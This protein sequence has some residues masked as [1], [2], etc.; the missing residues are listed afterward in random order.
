MQSRLRGKRR[1]VA[2]LLALLLLTLLGILTAGAVSATA[3]RFRTARGSLLDGALDAA[4]MNAIGTVVGSA[5]LYGLADLTFAQPTTISIPVPPGAGIEPIVASVVATRFAHGVVWLVAYARLA[6]DSAAGERRLNAVL[7]YPWIGELPPA[8]VVSR[9]A[10]HLDPDVL[11]SADTA[12]DLDC[13]RLAPEE[14]SVQRSDSAAFYL[15]AFQRALLDSAAG[16]VHVHG[17]TTVSGGSFDGI[18]IVDGTLTVAGPW[19]AAGLVI[20]GG[21]VESPSGL[22]LTGALL[23]FADGESPAVALAGA[24]LRYSPCTVARAFRRALPLRL[25]RPRAWAEVF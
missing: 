18:L 22:T 13:P 4:A 16:V 10:V 3:I 9:G 19:S 11:V 2:L 6:A 12:G 24:R 7:R 15:S 23:S 1:G 17:D 20:V 25:A 5:H 14:S 21:A 8:A